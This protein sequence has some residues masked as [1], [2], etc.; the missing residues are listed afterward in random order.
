[1]MKVLAVVATLMLAVWPAQAQ[2][3]EGVVSGTISKIDNA[4]KT[5]VIKTADAGEIVLKETAKTVKEG[6]AALKEGA[7]VVAHYT[8]VGAE[9]TA[10]ALKYVGSK[11][12]HV[13]EGT[14]DKVDDVAKTVAVKTK[15]GSVVVFHSAED[16]VLATGRGVKEGARVTVYYT[17]EAGRKIAHGFRHLM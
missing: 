3:R 5:V 9:H 1:M 2:E 17:E 13:A 16:G 15:D 6:G 12:V 11:T 14:V 7:Q 10:L 4:A 8:T